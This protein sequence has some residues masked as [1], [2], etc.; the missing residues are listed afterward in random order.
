[1]AESVVNE[2]FSGIF[3]VEGEVS[4]SITVNVY[5]SNDA[6]IATKSAV[7]RNAGYLIEHTFTSP[8]VYI[9]EVIDSDTNS[10]FD[11]VTVFSDMSVKVWD[12]AEATQMLTDIAFIKDIEG[13]R[14]IIDHNTNQMVFYKSDNVTEV[15]RFS[16]R[17]INGSPTSTN[18][19]QRT[20]L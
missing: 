8:G 11:T 13:G 7:R 15:A 12:A 5:N 6:L 16:L 10:H 3:R 4:P 1:M 2:V 14:W 20:R 19:F 17:D 9:I 18:V